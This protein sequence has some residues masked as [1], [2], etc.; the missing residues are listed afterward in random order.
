[1]QLIHT[2]NRATATGRRT[3]GGS[4]VPGGDVPT[5]TMGYGDESP[6]LLGGRNAE[7][8]AC[9]LLGLLKPGLRV[10]LMVPG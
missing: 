5:C 4:D 8:G 2:D 9:H 6:K 7:M 10:G 3:V 1:M